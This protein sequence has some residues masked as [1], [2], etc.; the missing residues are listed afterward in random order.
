MIQKLVI[1]GLLKKRPSSGYDIKKFI[2][3]D[4]KIFTDLDTHSIYYP[5]KKMEK[6]GFIKKKMLKG[7]KQLRKYVYFITPKGEKE[8]LALCRE[9]LL[10]QKRPFI[11]LDISLYFLPFLSKEEIKLLLRV[12]LRFLERVR[13][14]LMK[15][16]NEFKKAPKNLLLLIQH[17]LKLAGAEKEFLKDMIRAIKEGE[18]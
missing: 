10:S 7:E 4:L 12:R 14:W 18:V 15:K 9:T 5:L 3:K 17:H 1:L 11:D 13:K 6:E 16:K 2:E 8:F